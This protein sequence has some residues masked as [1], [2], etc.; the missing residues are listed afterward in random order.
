MERITYLD[1]IRGFAILLVI[2]GHMIQFNFV[3]GVESPIFNI[4]YSFHMPLFFFLSG[5]T[6]FLSEKGRGGIDSILKVG[7]L[8]KKKFLALIVPSMCWTMLI[9]LFFSA[10]YSFDK[11]IS[12]FWFLNT[13]FAISLFWIFRSFLYN[14]CHRSKFVDIFFV[15]LLIGL[16]LFGIKRVSL[17]YLFMFLC[18]YYFQQSN[19]LDKLKD[20]A[21]L[22]V[23]LGYCLGVGFFSYTKGGVETEDRVWLEFPLSICASICLMK[24]FSIFRENHIAKFLSFI[25]KYTLGIYLCHFVFIHQLSLEVLHSS[26]NKVCQFVI[27]ILLASIIAVLCV[28]LQR[29]TEAFPLLNNIMYGT[30]GRKKK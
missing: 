20:W 29:V 25:G 28:I 3:D 8:V 24:I 1:S 12:Y 10:D 30:F 22:F 27:L 17:M 2:V 19:A 11:G 4:I 6:T 15:S 9:P 5:C 18:G 16:F 7:H 23:L 13:L 21:Y 14:Y 26:F